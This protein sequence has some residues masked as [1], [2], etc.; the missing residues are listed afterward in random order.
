MDCAVIYSEA[1]LADLVTAF[2]AADN[3]LSQSRIKSRLSGTLPRCEPL[4]KRFP[5]LMRSPS[6]KNPLNTDVFIQ[7]RPMNSE[8]LPNKLMIVS[9]RSRAMQ[10]SRIPC[11]RR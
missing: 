8:A 3:A 2:I 10:Q 6:G 1:A 5:A 7:L 9:L 11:Q 4:L